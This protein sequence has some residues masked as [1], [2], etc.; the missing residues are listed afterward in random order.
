MNTILHLAAVLATLW[1][2][3]FAFETV[4]EPAL[5][6]ALLVLF[7][8]FV[9][10]TVNALDDDI[11][12]AFGKKMFGFKADQRSSISNSSII[13]L[14]A[15]LFVWAGGVSEHIGAQIATALT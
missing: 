6:G 9:A 12:L 1:A 15:T 5:G 14:L 4:E 13:A 3:V 8:G 2:S 7:F 11:F 10:L